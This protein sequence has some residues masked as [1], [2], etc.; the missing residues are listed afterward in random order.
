MGVFSADVNL[1]EQTQVADHK[2]MLPKF[3]EEGGD[4]YELIGTQTLFY[5]P[6]ARDSVSEWLRSWSRKPMG[7]AR[8]GSN[9]VAVAFC[10]SGGRLISCLMVWTGGREKCWNWRPPRP[11]K[12][13]PRSCENILMQWISQEPRPSC[14]VKPFHIYMGR[15]TYLK[16]SWM[17]LCL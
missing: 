7:S 5:F 15:P 10:I 14:S 6:R 11:Q 8:A 17:L 1:Q 13:M 3:L 9:P 16:K 2:R 4:V 12:G